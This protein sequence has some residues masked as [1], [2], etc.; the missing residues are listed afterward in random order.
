MKRMW[1]RKQ[2][3]LIQLKYIVLML[4]THTAHSKH[5]LI[6]FSSQFLRPKHVTFQCSSEISLLELE[7]VM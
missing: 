1:R 5:V 7:I 2:H 6:S 4:I 3:Y